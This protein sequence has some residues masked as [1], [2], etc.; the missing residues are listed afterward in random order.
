MKVKTNLK[1]DPFAYVF[2]APNSLVRVKHKAELKA[3]KVQLELDRKHPEP[4]SLMHKREKNGSLNE[5]SRK[6]MATLGQIANAARAMADW[7]SSDPFA[8]GRT[9]LHVSQ[10]FLDPELVVK[11]MTQRTVARQVAKRREVDNATA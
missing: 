7:D 3:R 6:G 1:S 9:A 2:P 8:Y 10:G 4:M 11:E 5:P